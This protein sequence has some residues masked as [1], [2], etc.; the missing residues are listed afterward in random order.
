[1]KVFKVPNLF[2]HIAKTV[3]KKL[4]FQVSFC[5]NHKISQL[6]RLREASRV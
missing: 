3:E 4:S 6:E 2:R 5:G 1:M